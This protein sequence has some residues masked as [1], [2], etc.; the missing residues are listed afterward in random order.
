MIPDGS[1]GF[2]SRL[3]WGLN[4][5]KYVIIAKTLTA[6]R[7]T[8]ILAGTLMYTVFS[9]GDAICADAQAADDKPQLQ[10]P[11]SGM[12]SIRYVFSFSLSGY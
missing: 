10:A 3:N 5:R 8:D 9:S 6:R 4:T 7:W 2:F 11:D 12:L 1:P